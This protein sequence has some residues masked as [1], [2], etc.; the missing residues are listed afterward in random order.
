MSGTHSDVE[1]VRQRSQRL[2]STSIGRVPNAADHDESDLLWPG[3]L[4][5]W[6]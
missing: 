1:L 3:R 5:S 2:D 6:L 4:P